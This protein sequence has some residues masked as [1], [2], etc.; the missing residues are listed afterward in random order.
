MSDLSDRWISLPRA[1]RWALVGGGLI[2][3]Y[4]VCVEPIVDRINSLN[5]AAGTRAA[6][7][8]AHAKNAAELQVKAEKVALGVRHFG[9]VQM[10]GDPEQ[11][12]LEFNRAVDEVLKKN[13]VTEHTAT[14]R[15]SPMGAGP[16]MATVG[17]EFRVDR[18]IKDIQFT[19]DPPVVAAVIADLER[20]PV[21]AAVSR[22]Q[23]RQADSRDK[24]VKQVRVTLD[25]EA[26]LLARKGKAR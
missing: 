6:M 20:S 25:A 22:L 26:W 23:I 3:V 17:S 15:T 10:P 16:L 8:A 19:A 11:R 7:L 4:F 1:V 13:G 9:E 18:L 12:A 14:T 21:V 24:S 2:V 5:G